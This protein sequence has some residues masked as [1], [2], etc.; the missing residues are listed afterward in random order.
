M[1]EKIYACLLRLFPPHFRKAYGDE[2]VQLFRDRARDEKGFFPR[3]RLWL[4]LLADLAISLPRQY[5]YVRPVLAGTAVQHRVEGA[6]AFFVLVNEPPGSGALIF[7][8]VLSMI[9][10]SLFSILL[11]R[12]GNHRPPTASAYQ[13]RHAIDS[14][15]STWG[16][17][18]GQ[19]PSDAKDL[20]T[21]ATRM[22]PGEAV[23]NDSQSKALLPP[24]GHRFPEG[25]PPQLQDGAERKRL[26]NAVIA[27][28]KRHYVEQ[29]VAREPADGFVGHEKKGHENKVTDGGPFA[30]LLTKQIS[31]VSHDMLLEV[32]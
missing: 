16:H 9:A 27:N 28:L 17:P 10:L 23:P 1:S 25:L 14:R 20:T 22:T 26:M 30:D 7:G 18:T 19:V 21:N 31:Q 11:G 4:D 5:R 6:P 12:A 13:Q 3:V 2:A 29:V 32:V 8:C 24:D 15:L